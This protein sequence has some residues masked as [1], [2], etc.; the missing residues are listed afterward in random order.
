MK[1]LTVAA[2]EMSARHK[3]FVILSV[4]KIQILQ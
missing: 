2:L 1:P 3:N 4:P